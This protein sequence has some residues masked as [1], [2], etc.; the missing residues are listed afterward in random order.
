MGSLSGWLF[1]R[2]R[3]E[4]APPLR[5]KGKDKVKNGAEKREGLKTL[6]H[7]TGGANLS[8]LHV[9]T[10]AGAASGALTSA[11]KCRPYFSAAPRDSKNAGWQPALRTP[12]LVNVVLLPV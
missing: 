11:C 7:K 12:S 2:R 4:Q 3:A 1:L 10:A 5:P 8:A 9:F 6:P